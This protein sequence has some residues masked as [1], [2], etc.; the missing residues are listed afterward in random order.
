MKIILI[1][2]GLFLGFVL[3][4]TMLYVIVELVQ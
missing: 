3:T 1:P 4:V 2:M